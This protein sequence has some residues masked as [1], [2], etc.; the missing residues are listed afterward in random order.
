MDCRTVQE[1]IVD[2]VDERA[3]DVPARAHV[4]GCQACAA[5]AAGQASMDARLSR[6]LVAPRL[7]C[8]FRAELR[9][10]IAGERRTWVRDAV[11]D[12]LHFIGWSVLTVATAAFVS[13][14]PLFVFVAGA[15]TALSTYVVLTVVRST[16]EDA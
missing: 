2:R 9:S 7:S 3:L 4:A 1:Q 15:L 10:K 8:G 11:P 6:A 12:I 13:V 14:D 16:L 5:F